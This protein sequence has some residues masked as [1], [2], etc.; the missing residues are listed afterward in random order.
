[1]KKCVLGFAFRTCEQRQDKLSESVRVRLQGAASDIHAAGGR[2]H[3]QCYKS[4][5]STRMVESVSKS[6]S[7]S[8]IS[9]KN[10]SLEQVIYAIRLNPESI[11]NSTEVHTLYIE[12]EGIESNIHR[13]ILEKKQDTDDGIMFLISPGIATIIMLKHKAESILKLEKDNDEDNSFAQINFAAKPIVSETK[14]LN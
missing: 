12:M 10:D 1:M 5:A 8:L 7:C 2:F 6:R 3:V 9:N 13:F 11:W 14:A 4:F